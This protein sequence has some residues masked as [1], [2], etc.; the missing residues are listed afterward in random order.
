MAEQRRNIR[1]NETLSVPG[2]DDQRAVVACAVEDVRLLVADHAQRVAALQHAHGAKQRAAHIALVKMVEQMGDHL[3]V[4]LADEARAGALQISAQGFMVFDDAV[5]H[6]RDAALDVR[7]GMGVEVAGFAVRGPARVAD[8]DHALHRA[9]VKQVFEV[10]QPA[11]GL[12]HVDAP[13]RPDH[14]HACAVVAPIG[15][16]LQSLNKNGR[17]LLASNIADDSAHA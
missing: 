16:P 6:H 7:M 10:F 1:R 5:V 13:L 8:A 4:R 3:G 12:A 11:L 17:G 9:L 15:K 14:R 2:A